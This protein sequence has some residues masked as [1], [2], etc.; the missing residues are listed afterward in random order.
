MAGVPFVLRPHRDALLKEDSNFR[1]KH[2]LYELNSDD[3]NMCHSNPTTASMLDLS[4]QYK[5]ITSRRRG[6]S[7]LNNIT[8]RREKR[9][10]TRSKRGLRRTLELA[11]FVDRFLYEHMAKN[12]RLNTE[13]YL[14]DVVLTMIN[15]VSIHL[16]TQYR[17]IY[18]KYI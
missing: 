8:S 17:I 14:T 13:R 11:V 3:K 7:S 4:F 16:T 1:R 12:F 6:D 10:L 2:L 9:S 15:A 5:N 18:S